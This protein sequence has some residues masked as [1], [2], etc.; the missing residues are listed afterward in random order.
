MNRFVSRFTRC[1]SKHRRSVASVL[2]VSA[3]AGCS[4]L[5][6]RSAG[7]RLDPWE[8]WNRDVF[9]FNEKLDERVLKPVA[10][11]Y[12]NVVPR[13]VRRGVD[14][15]FSNVADAWSAINNVLQAKWEPAFTDVV[16]VTDS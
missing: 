4:T 11:V 5:G 15:F 10:T 13:P 7:Q 6:G 1:F 14:N 9:A 2:I 16:R 8:P 3:L 12:S